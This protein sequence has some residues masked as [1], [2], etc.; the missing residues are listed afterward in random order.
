M[1]KLPVD[2]FID[3]LDRSG[4]L[5]KDQVEPVMAALREENAGQE[6][7]DGQVLADRLVQQR[8]L[9]RWQTTKLM[10][11]R[12]KGFFL[13]KYRLLDHLGSGGMSAVYLA[14]HMVMER[15]VAIKVLPESKVNDSSY[16]PRFHREARAAAALDHPNIVRA[17]DVDN[18]G[19]N[20]YLVMEYVDGRN[21]QEI[22]AKEGPLP[23]E[24]AAEYIRQA[25]DGLA[26][27]HAVGLV[28]RDI[29]PANLL[30]D[31]RKTVKVL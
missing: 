14:E 27:A 28:H 11:G 30:V 26:H 31:T 25:A 7:T 22:V 8:L 9:T 24:I 18:D 16:L 29:K 17:Y 23:F 10:E 6:I 15:R 21:L 2:R 12:H 1:P 3:L 13:G 4:L 19:P 5:K 20:H